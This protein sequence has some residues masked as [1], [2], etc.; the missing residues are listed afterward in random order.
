[1]RAVMTE[2]LW[3][4]ALGSLEGLLGDSEPPRPNT[5]TYQD[6]CHLRPKYAASSWRVILG[7]LVERR[8]VLKTTR[9]GRVAFQLTRQ[10]ER[11]LRGLYP[12]FSGQTETEWSLLLLKPLP[13]KIR[14][15]GE[16]KRAMKQAGHIFVSS[17]TA[18]KPRAEFSD[19]LVKT[20]AICGYQAV[21]VPF[22]PGKSQ[23]VP[24]A[25]FLSDQEDGFGLSREWGKISKEVNTLLMELATKKRLKNQT[26]E[27]IGNILLS[28]LSFF[29]RLNWLDLE[30]PQSRERIF[31]LARQLD[32]LAQEYAEINL[33]WSGKNNSRE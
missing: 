15:L 9:E 1:M 18:I 28:G 13:G 24:L 26:K 2:V 4:L 29:S 5:L 6:F 19:Y 10:G 27:R 25:E 21:F 23:P 16:A 32:Q 8:L 30:E 14:R 33:A 31:Q 22:S 17:L 7:K 12:V 11:E 3:F 20:L